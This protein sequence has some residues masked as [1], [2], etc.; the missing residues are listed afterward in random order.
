VLPICADSLPPLTQVA[1]GHL[2]A[3]LRDD[4]LL[5]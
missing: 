1:P 2:K 3:C 5:P 4:I